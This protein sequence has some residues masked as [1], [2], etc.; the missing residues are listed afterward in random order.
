MKTG[1]GNVA[2]SAMALAVRGALLAMCAA[3]MVAAAQDPA[4]ADVRSLTVPTSTIEVGG[5]Y[6]SKDSTKFGEFNGLNKKG[7]YLIGN[8]DARGGKGYGLGATGERWRIFGNDL[9][10][11][12]RSLGASAE[13]QGKWSFGVGFDQLRHYTTTGYQTP[14][15]GSMGGNNFTLPSSFGTIDAS[16][17]AAGATALTANQRGSFHSEDVYTQRENTSVTAGYHFNREWNVKLDFNELNQS[18]AKL[19]SSGTDAFTGGPGGFNYGAERAAMLMNPT[20]Y[21]TDS[22]TATLNWTSARGHLTMGY[23]GSLFHDDYSGLTFSN[24]WTSTAGVATG[25]NPGAAFPL[26]TMS[27][28]PSNQFHQ[29]N[30]TGGYRLSA[31]TN[32]AGGLSYSRNTQDQSFSGTYT[33]TPNTV[34]ALGAASLGGLVVNT[35]ADLKVSHQATRTLGLS[36]GFIYNERDNRTPSNAYTFLNLGGDVQDVVNA[37]MS[38]RR[39]QFQLAG[40]YRIDARQRL[41]AGYEHEDFKR[42]C[43]NSLANNAQGDIPAGYATTA[44]YYTTA[45]CTQTPQSKDNRFDLKYNL[46]ASD[47]A[48]VHAAYGY[49]DRKS[50]VNSSFYNPMQGN[51][52][53][54][55]VI[56]HQAFFQASRKENLL[57]AGVDWQASERFNLGVSGRYAKDKY[58]ETLGVQEG[59]AYSA[60]LD[61]TYTLSESSTVSVFYTYQNRKRD[62]RNGSPT[63]GH[64]FLLLTKFWTN[65]LT[66]Q[67]NTFGINGKENGLLGGRLD[68]TQAL[69]YSAAKTRYSTAQQTG[70]IALGATGDTPD[71]KSD[72][73]QL[74][75]AGTYHLNKTADVIAGYTY[76]HL[77]SEDYF[78]NGYQY[79]LTPTNVLPN[80]LMAPNYSVNAVFAAYKYKFQ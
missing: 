65:D 40:D 61:G 73:T 35:H 77:K 32:L 6:V 52:E 27:T 43:N 57:K 12:S 66:D 54:Y 60:N 45:S 47:T 17:G 24:P 59:K 9:G 50:D 55:E 38:H 72:M 80:Y 51:E 1:E 21:K 7:G 36:A 42:W 28:P 23:Y 3:P 46:R 44:V 74:K 75:L 22:V 4:N 56:G 2:V 33:T 14:Y 19:I 26:D 15:D 5:L 41:H 68:L 29:L 25:T 30:L 10:T 64:N 11:N 18:G 71:I 78:Y 76:M 16:R 39:T 62:L 53:G 67:D 31:A 8:V 48:N 58:D 20:K 70:A 49:S 69:T 37:P 79:G 34:P 63:A 13:D